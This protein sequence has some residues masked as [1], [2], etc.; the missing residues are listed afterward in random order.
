MYT[1]ADDWGQALAEEEDKGW[2]MNA[3]ERRGD[4]GGQKESFFPEIQPYVVTLSHS[5][6]HSEAM[7]KPWKGGHEGHITVPAR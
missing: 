5:H 3:G 6:W 2:F 1:T 4:S 7:D